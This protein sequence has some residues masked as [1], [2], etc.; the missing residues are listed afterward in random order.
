MVSTV[1]SKLLELFN[2]YF[3]EYEFKAASYLAADKGL[4]AI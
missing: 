3:Q 2:Y 4:H 1:R